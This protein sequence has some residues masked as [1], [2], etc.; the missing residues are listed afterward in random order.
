[1]GM[2]GQILRATVVRKLLRG[3]VY[4]KAGNLLGLL[5]VV[6]QNMVE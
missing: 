2:R 6:D 4:K 3:L 5:D 1:M